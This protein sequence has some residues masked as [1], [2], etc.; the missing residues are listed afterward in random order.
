[1][2]NEAGVQVSDTTIDAARCISLNKKKQHCSFTM[3][4]FSPY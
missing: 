2:R 3:L 4:L 1:M